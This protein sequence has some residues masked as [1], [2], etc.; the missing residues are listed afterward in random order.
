MDAI[1]PFPFLNK[2]CGPHRVAKA[3]ISPGSAARPV[4]E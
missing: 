4:G 1:D 2:E 3:E